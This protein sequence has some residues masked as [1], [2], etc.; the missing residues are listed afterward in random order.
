MGV[1]VLGNNLFGAQGNTYFVDP[2]VGSDSNSGKTVSAALKTVS[3]AYTKC[4]GGQ[5]DVVYLLSNGASTSG[6]GTADVLTTAITWAKHRTHLIGVCAPHLLGQ[7]A[8]INTTT[9]MTPMF[10]LSG[11]GCYIA[12]IQF[13]NN[14]THATTAAVCMY[15]TGD[16]SYFENC[17]FQGL[18]AL[19]VVDNSHRSL[20][21]N[22]ADDC[23]F[24]NCTIGHDT[25]DFG[26]ATNYVIEFTA[27]GEASRNV[28]D[29]CLL[30][31]G[32]SANACFVLQGAQGTASA[33]VFKNCVM[34]NNYNG[35]MD[36]MTYAMNT[37]AGG[38]VFILHDTSITGAADIADDPGN[39][40]SNRPIPASATDAGL[41][42]VVTKT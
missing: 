1:P 12:N 27:A 9:L 28:F 2:V 17:Q 39:I 31:G 15:V 26:T 4:V 23:M 33:T 42:I 21:I 30:L 20:V 5:N 14:G 41:T 24:K 18:G 40:L 7:R 3:A 35:S 13:S 6:A 10:T 22:S 11:R 38:G 32:G 19:A 36:E 16:N 25:Q 37:S 34:Y 29:N 8:R